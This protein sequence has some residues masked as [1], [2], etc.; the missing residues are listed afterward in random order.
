VCALLR[1]RSSPEK[2]RQFQQ[3]ETIKRE[4]FFNE[5]LPILLPGVEYDYKTEVEKVLKE[6]PFPLPTMA[7]E[8]VLVEDDEEE[9]TKI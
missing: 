3:D 1:I 9:E 2:Y 8:G 4:V 5:T 7:E 6:N